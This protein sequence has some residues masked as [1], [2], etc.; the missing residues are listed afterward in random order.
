MTE[1]DMAI[2]IRRRWLTLM[3]MGADEIE[4]D[5]RRRPPCCIADENRELDAV[6]K[7]RRLCGE[8]T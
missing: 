1:Q 4:E 3:G 7:I 5:I 8:S 6:Y 2:E